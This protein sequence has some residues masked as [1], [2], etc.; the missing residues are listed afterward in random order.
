[1]FKQVFL[2]TTVKLYKSIFDDFLEHTVI[3]FNKWT[4]ADPNESQYREKQYQDIFKNEYQKANIPCFFIDSHF[5]L[6]KIR[7]NEN[8]DPQKLFLNKRIQQ[9]TL[10]QIES[11][12][13]FLETKKIRCDVSKAESKKPEILEIKE[14]RDEFKDRSTLYDEYGSSTVDR[15]L[16][17]HRF[18]ESYC[19]SDSDWYLTGFKTKW[20]G[21]FGCSNYESGSSRGWASSYGAKEH[22]TMDFLKTHISNGRIKRKDIEK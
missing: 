1:M 4:S 12:F 2:K 16:S 13:L 6:E 19:S 14:E 9:K 8:G 10:D 17:T 22:A 7:Y 11:L 15:L 5:N 18:L 20:R 3:V 21:S